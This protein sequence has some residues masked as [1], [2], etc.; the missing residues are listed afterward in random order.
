MELQCQA[1]YIYVAEILHE[2]KDVLATFLHQITCSWSGNLFCMV[3]PE[4][5]TI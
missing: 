3:E 2:L 1:V 5:A 4:K